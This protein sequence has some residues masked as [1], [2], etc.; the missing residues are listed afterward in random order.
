MHTSKPD[1]QT[2][3]GATLA[4]SHGTFLAVNSW[5]LIKDIACILKKN[6]FKIIAYILAQ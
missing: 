6:I 4:Q 1:S 3:E 5:M 2:T